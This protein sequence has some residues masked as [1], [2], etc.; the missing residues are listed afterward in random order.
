MSSPNALSPSTPDTTKSAAS[1]FPLRVSFRALT[2]VL[3]VVGTGAR[4][5]HFIANPSLWLDELALARNI[6]ER[7]WSELL[8]RPL[9]YDQ[10]APLGF[11]ALEKLAVTALGGEDY[12]LRLLPMLCSVVSLFLMWRVAIFVVPETIVPLVVGMLALSPR[13]IFWLGTAKQ[14]SSDVTMALVLLYTGIRFR[15]AANPWKVVAVAGAT[16][17]VAVWISQPAIFVAAGVWL[18][19]A[20]ICVTTRERHRIL[21]LLVLAMLWGT[22]S[23]VAAFVSI[24][25]VAPA[26]HDYL[27]VVWAGGFL[28]VPWKIS[29]GALWLWRRFT[30]VFDFNLA[31]PLP[32]LFAGLALV[33]CLSLWQKNWQIASLVL[34][35]LFIALGASAAWL[36]PFEKR[37]LFYLTPAFLLSIGA[38]L[39]LLTKRT[40]RLQVAGPLALLLLGIPAYAFVSRPPPYP[41]EETKA[42]LAQIRQALEEGDQM[43]VYYGGAHAIKFYGEKFGFVQDQYTL[44]GCHRGDWRAYFREIDAFRGAPR[45]WVLFSH[46]LPNLKEREVI[47]A[48]LREIGVE[49]ETLNT[50][51]ERPEMETTAHLFDLSDARL[52]SRAEAATFS[53]DYPEIDRNWYA[54]ERGPAVLGSKEE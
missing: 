39:G 13:A 43:Y 14:Y 41:C 28:P 38:A 44:G 31:Y 45:L 49:R 18:A 37:L 51:D 20:V 17:A 5:V 19:L 36:Y 34:T 42:A 12:V 53:F 3:V 47:L 7:S 2:C 33:G 6:V 26:T 22:S 35:P 9:D 27:N 1:H 24:N 4:L 10:V 29:S 16:G 50:P 40:L 48:Y 21:P 15:D 25:R 46:S 8:L 52:L 54:S 11:L 23:I 32:K 30:L